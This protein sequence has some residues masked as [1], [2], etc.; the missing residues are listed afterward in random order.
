M[1]H[2]A[3]SRHRWAKPNNRRNFAWDVPVIRQLTSHPACELSSH[4]CCCVN[5]PVSFYAML[6]FCLFAVKTPNWLVSEKF[7]TREAWQSFLDICA[8]SFP[9]SAFLC[10]TWTSSTRTKGQGCGCKVGKQPALL[11]VSPSDLLLYGL[12]VPGGNRPSD[13]QDFEAMCDSPPCRAAWHAQ[14]LCTAPFCHEMCRKLSSGCSWAFG[15]VNWLWIMQEVCVQ[16][17][18]VFNFVGS[19]DSEYF[20]FWDW[21]DSYCMLKPLYGILMHC[22]SY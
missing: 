8:A 7:S 22:S 16:L 12:M 21:N 1:S 13:M 6:C 14:Q 11:L 3:V 5:A 10:K 9:V 17:P 20:L 18:W 4:C 15:G 2:G 19:H